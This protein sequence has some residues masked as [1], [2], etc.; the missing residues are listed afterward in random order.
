MIRPLVADAR[1]LAERLLTDLPERWQHTV[2]VAERAGQISATVPAGEADVL[3][4]AAWLHDIGYAEALHD[5]GF[6]PID[7]ARHL[8]DLAWP[9]RI[10]GLVAHHSGAICVAHVR[11][12][13]AALAEFPQESTPVSDGLTYADQTVGPYGRSMDF[14]ERMADMLRR[15]GP[16]SPNAAVHSRR[17]PM[18]RAAVQRVVSRLA[19]PAGVRVA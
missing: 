15:H 4:A 11:G 6:H 7:G 14:E 2:G 9:L 5:T 16:G 10:A 18:L 8:R 17:A 3:V 19:I 1:D 12:L 13:G